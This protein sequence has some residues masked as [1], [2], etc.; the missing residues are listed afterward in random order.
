MRLEEIKIDSPDAKELEIYASVSEPQLRH[1]YEPE[2]G[3]FIAESLKI[4][5]RALR[6]G[7][8][9]LSFFA[10]EK[11]VPGLLSVLE[12]FEEEAAA[13]GSR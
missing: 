13:A 2:P 11:K 6:A 1:Y 3:I 7:Y 5:P 12:D 9:P 8:E 10:D 4:I